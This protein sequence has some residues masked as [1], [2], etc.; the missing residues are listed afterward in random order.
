MSNLPVHHSSDARG[1][2]RPSS[3]DHLTMAPD[4]PDDGRHRLA[5]DAVA[6]LSGPVP[7]YDVADVVAAR[8]SGT[9]VSGERRYQVAMGLHHATLPDLD[10]AGLL[11]YDWTWR[12]VQRLDWSETRDGTVTP[13]AVT[14]PSD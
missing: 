14:G 5:L 2:D 11:S 4:R 9:P 8:E 1:T 7:L 12:T 13:R 3:A 10:D 6:G